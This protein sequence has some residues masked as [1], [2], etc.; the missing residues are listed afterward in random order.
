[1]AQPRLNRS[2]LPR[3]LRLTSHPLKSEDEVVTVVGSSSLDSVALT[4][5][6]GDQLPAAS[7]VSHLAYVIG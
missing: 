5:F 6:I 4:S 7:L 2:T 1:M 3:R